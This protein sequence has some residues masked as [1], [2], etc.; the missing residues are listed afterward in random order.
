LFIGVHVSA[1]A[2]VEGEHVVVL[3]TIFLMENA[4]AVNRIISS[5][6]RGAMRRKEE[7][8]LIVMVQQS[9]TV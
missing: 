7:E 6:V 3:G 1:D 4:S 9:S 8:P 2:A 5:R